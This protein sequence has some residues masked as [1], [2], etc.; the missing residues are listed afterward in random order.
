MYLRLWLGAY[1]EDSGAKDTLVYNGVENTH[2]R[3]HDRRT[4]ATAARWMSPEGP[5]NFSP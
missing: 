4:T 3:R 2:L 5:E 1:D